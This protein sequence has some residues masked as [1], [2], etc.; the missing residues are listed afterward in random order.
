MDKHVFTMIES[1][2]KITPETS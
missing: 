1:H 2:N